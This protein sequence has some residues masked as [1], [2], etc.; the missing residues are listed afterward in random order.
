MSVF[1]EKSYFK[2]IS[3]LLPDQSPRL[4]YGVAVTDFDN[5]GNDEFIVTGFR[6]RI[7]ALGFNGERFEN[8]IT[9]NIFSEERS[10][11]GVAACDIDKDGLEEIYFLNTDTY[12]GHENVLRQIINKFENKIESIYLKKKLIKVN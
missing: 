1:A 5:D 11:I 9:D 4:S 2:N 7:L 12:S 3:N 6:F 10:T 8:K